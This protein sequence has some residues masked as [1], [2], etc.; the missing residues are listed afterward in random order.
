MHRI[1]LSIILVGLLNV[2]STESFSHNR[3]ID[4]AGL[5]NE[6]VFLF[7]PDAVQNHYR[8]SIFSSRAILYRGGT[9]DDSDC[10]PYA[11]CGVVP[12]GG[13]KFVAEFPEQVIGH[14]TLQIR[15]LSDE[16]DTAIS[17]LF[18]N[19][20]ETFLSEAEALSGRI[21]FEFSGVMNFNHSLDYLVPSKDTITVHGYIVWGVKGQKFNMAITGGTGRYR[22]IEGQAEFTRLVVANATGANSFRIKLPRIR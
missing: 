8:G 14:A 22:S 12:S 19:D 11:F 7:A 4:L 18:V 6:L 13:G 16:M 15:V 21:V 5:G 10:T 2:Y 9:L 17:T 20:R 3:V 1:A